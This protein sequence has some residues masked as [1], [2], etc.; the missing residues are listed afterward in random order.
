MQFDL[1]I[2]HGVT[3]DNGPVARWYDTGTCRVWNEPL[4]SVSI[5]FREEAYDA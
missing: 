5:V 1:K 3:P 4:R 2:A